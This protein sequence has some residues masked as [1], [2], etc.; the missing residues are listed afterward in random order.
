MTATP[1]ARRRRTAAWLSSLAV[2][3]IILA[4]VALWRDAARGARPEV[5]GPVLPDWPAQAET[6]QII[7]ITAADTMFRLVRGED[8]WTMPSR[9]GYPV[10]PE[11]IAALDGALAELRYRRVMTRDPDKL[12]RLGLGDP[13]AGGEGVRLTVVAEDGSRLADLIVGD[14]RGETGAYIRPAGGAR[15]YSVE[16]RLP[17]L[18]DAGAWLGLDFM[19]IDPDRVAAAEIEPASGPGYR[20][21]KPGR[22]SRNFELRRPDGWSMITAGAG[23]G[24]AVAGARVRFRDV[25]PESEITRRVVARHAGGAFDGL[26]YAYTFRI[27][28]GT[29]WATID[30]QALTDDA[31]AEAERFDALAEGWAFRVSEDAYERMTRP[32]TG[33]AERPAPPEPEGE[34]G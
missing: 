16:G 9:G 3:V 24:V 1:A 12:S 30:F 32:L 25:R 21:E 29:A 8:G 13:T 28:D 20:L 27:Q 17:D 26:V 18:A 14:A 19:N 15:A 5:A 4:G 33:L 23:N 31:Q 6:A 7:E 10:R 22:A 11:R 2:L 34:G